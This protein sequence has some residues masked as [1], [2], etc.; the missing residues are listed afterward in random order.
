MKLTKRFELIPFIIQIF[1]SRMKDLID[2]AL[3]ERMQLAQDVSS[4]ILISS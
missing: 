1:L 2:T 3:E 4:L